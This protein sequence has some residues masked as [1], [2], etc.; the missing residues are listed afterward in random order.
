MTTVFF[1]VNYTSFAHL[2][3]TKSEICSLQNTS[4]GHVTQKRKQKK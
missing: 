3:S 2:L 1:L 4:L